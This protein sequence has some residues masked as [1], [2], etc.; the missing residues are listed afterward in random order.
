M[1]E[2]ALTQVVLVVKNPPSNA[3]DTRD[4]GSIPGSGRPPGGGNGNPLQYSCLGNPMDR[5]AWWATVHWV[6]KSWTQLSTHVRM[7][8][9]I[10]I[11]SGNCFLNTSPYG[12]STWL[13]WD[14]LYH[15]SYQTSYAVV[16]YSK[17]QC[18][19]RHICHQSIL[20]LQWG[21]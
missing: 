11:L 12:L 10:L 18:S 7:H 8:S 9:T 13:A 20:N 1:T 15:R 14:T 3:R 21:T 4:V 17:K 2:M 6:A 16:Q 19:R 5:G